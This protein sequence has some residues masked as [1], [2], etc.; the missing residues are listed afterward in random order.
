MPAIRHTAR[1]YQNNKGSSA[2]SWDTGTFPGAVTHGSLLPIST[3]S[4][5]PHYVLITISYVAT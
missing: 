5:D 4:S 2:K 1:R 3:Y